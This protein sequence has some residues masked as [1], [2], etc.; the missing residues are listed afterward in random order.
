VTNAKIYQDYLKKYPQY[1]PMLAMMNSQHVDP[2]PPVIIQQFLMDKIN[3]KQDLALRGVISPAQAVKDLTREV[4]EEL[5]RR[6][7]LGYAE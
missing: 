7:K 4:N 2:S 5:G 3:Q 6:R 1:R